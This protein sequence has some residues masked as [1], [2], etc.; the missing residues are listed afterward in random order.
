[1][2]FSMNELQRMLQDSAQDFGR[3]HG[4][5]ERR[6][7]LM[8][9]D[10]GFSEQDWSLM[11]ELGWMS[12]LLPESQGGIGGGPIETM[13]VM[14]ALGQ[15]LAMEPYLST[16]VIGARALVAHG[17]AEQQVRYLED[18]AQGKLR[19]AFAHFEQGAHQNPYAVALQALAHG[20]GYTLSGHKRMVFD[21]PSADLLIVTA[22]VI[23]N[24]AQTSN[25]G[26]EGISVF[27]VPTQGEGVSQQTFC[28]LDGGRASHV[29]FDNVEVSGAQLLGRVHHGADIVDDLYA[30]G[31]GA[32]CA[33]ALGAMQVMHDASLDYIKVRK[34]FGR[35]IGSFQALQHRQVDMYAAL[36]Q[37]RSITMA[38]NMALAAQ[39]ADAMRLLSMAKVQCGRSAQI[40]GQG[41]VQLHGGIGMTEELNVGA[42]FKRTTVIDAQFG[43]IQQHLWQLSQPTATA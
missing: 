31:I 28:R 39:S 40:I 13:V 15:S 23:P 41:A 22:R 38:A 2:N 29:S 7:K 21:G 33:E 43:N 20:D 10:L 32:L 26:R 8:D 42:Y 4:D 6:R 9:S 1:M 3:G 12:L 34:Q 37:A 16:A 5:Y 14:E 27:L 25:T 24:G 17:S 30:H 11:A 35:A 36:E 18:L 19:I